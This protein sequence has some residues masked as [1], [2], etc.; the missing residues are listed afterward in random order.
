MRF[1]NGC[2]ETQHD[3]FEAETSISGLGTTVSGLET[4]K[5]SG[6]C[7]SL[8]PYGVAGMGLVIGLVSVV[9]ND[10]NIGGFEVAE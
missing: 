9:M 5:G 1:Q 10:V 3:S 4:T 7:K 8:M 6:E 2:I